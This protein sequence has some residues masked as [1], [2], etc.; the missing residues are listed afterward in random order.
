MTMRISGDG[1]DD[2]PGSGLSRCFRCHCCCCGWTP[3][4]IGENFHH[5]DDHDHLND[6]NHDQHYNAI[7]LSSSY[8]PYPSPPQTSP[9]QVGGCPTGWTSSTTASLLRTTYCYR[10]HVTFIPSSPPQPSP[11]QVGG[12]PTGWTSSTTASL[13]RTTYCYRSHITFIS[14]AL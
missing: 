2:E 1:N 4:K 10:S 12:C 14:T 13:L 5:C 8:T 6:N 11:S 7:M 9:S 3:F